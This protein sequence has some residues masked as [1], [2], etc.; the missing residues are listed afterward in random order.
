MGFACHA[1]RN[2]IVKLGPTIYKNNPTY[3]QV[4]CYTNQEY[5][6][7]PVFDC[8]GYDEYKDDGVIIVHKNNN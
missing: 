1:C 5:K 3:I 2:K 4:G 7:D 8:P 6:V